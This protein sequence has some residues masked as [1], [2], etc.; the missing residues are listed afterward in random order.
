MLRIGIIGFKDCFCYAELVNSHPGFKLS[1]IFDPA[2]Q[3]DTRIVPENQPVFYELSDVLDASQA[4]L[5]ASDDPNYYAYIIEAIK[6]SKPVFLHSTHNLSVHEHSQLSKI[7]DEAGEIIQVRHD[8]AFHRA[9]QNYIQLTHTPLL[10]DINQV[11]S[12]QSNLLISLRSNISAVLKVV[13]SNIRKVTV[14]AVASFN[15]IPDIFNVRI[16]FDNGTFVKIQINSIEREV[17]HKIKIFEYN[18]YFNIDILEHSLYSTKKTT[19]ALFTEKENSVQKQIYRQ[20]DAFYYSVI[21]FKETF[22]TID[23][24]LITQKVIEKVKEKIKV[25]FT[26]F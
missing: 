25:C 13:K 8:F 2:F 21:Q 20:I 1:G 9:F 22:N 7:G 11:V 15:N 3:F 19:E 17:L 24:E 16:D 12:K 5:V 26:I 23:N 4:I 10:V 18:E 6:N 14:N